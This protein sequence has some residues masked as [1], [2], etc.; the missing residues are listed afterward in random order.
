MSAFIG[1]PGARYLSQDGKDGADICLARVI[2]DEGIEH[3]FDNVVLASG[4]GGLAPFVAH[5]ATKGLNTTVV[6]PANRLSRQMRMAAHKCIVLTPELED[7][8]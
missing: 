5:L 6:S 2:V 4:D 3:R 7:I 8:A 1:W